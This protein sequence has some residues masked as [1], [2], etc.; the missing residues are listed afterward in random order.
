MLAWP[1]VVHAAP[2]ESESAPVV[3][4]TAEALWEKAVTARDE[5]KILAAAVYFQRF[6]KRF[7]DSDQ[8]EDALWQ[9]AQLAKKHA[10]TANDPNWRYVRDLFKRYTVDY[11][12]SPRYEEAYYEQAV[13]YYNMRM[14]REALIYFNLFLE[15]FPKSTFAQQVSYLK[16]Q[17]FLKIGRLADATKI[18]NLLTESKDQSL[19]LQGFVG[20]GDAL[21]AGGQNLAALA[22]YKKV[23]SKS[24][25]Y[26][27]E[28]PVLL[29]KL[30]KTYFRVGN[31]D[32]GRKQLFHYLNLD[33]T[34]HRR[35]EVVFEIGESFHR[36]G[37]EDAAQRLYEMAVKEGAQD[38]RSVVLSLFRQAQHR[39]DP[40]REIP[41]WKKPTDLTDPAG[42][43]PY[44]DV[45]DR[46]YGEPIAQDARLA[47][48]HR[49]QARKDI[50]Q[51]LSVAVSFIQ[52][53][54]EGPRRLEMESLVGD[55]LVIR[56]QEYLAAGRYQDIYD[57]YRADYRHV[58][59][60]RKG[61]LLYLI[62]QALEGLTLYDQAAVIYYRALALP[63]SDVDKADLYY[64]RATVYI[65]KKDWTAADRL[66]THLRKTYKGDQV[67]GEYIYLSGCLREAQGKDDEAL[68][69]YLEAIDLLA[70][71]VRKPLC[72]KAALKLLVLKGRNDETRSLL[73]RF[74]KDKWLTPDEMQNWYS[75]LADN[76][77]RAG[78]NP[79]AVKVYL[80]ALAKGMPQE[81]ELT[82]SLQVRLGGTFV[83][84]GR[85]EEA[86]VYFDKARSGSSELWRRVAGE[87]L[88]Q[89]EIDSS[90]L[91]LETILSQ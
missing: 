76:L 12:K 19:R 43:K 53:E 88:A 36:Q 59:A 31:E 14:F 64:R 1:A 4:L 84:L 34:S 63:L 44:L 54:P 37:D 49:Y 16:G 6:Q 65:A 30:G 91:T 70:G 7:P 71:S 18:F 35:S 48:I 33:K 46:Y 42:D 22:A 25:G 13:A 27:F 20:L 86:K 15:R 38:E 24:P 85:L 73:A 41:D 72:A 23:L 81:G 80:M 32:Q 89:M 69:Y 45:V 79:G 83:L 67:A 56:V 29:I 68:T 5:G 39:D 61:R 57:L 75:R 90:M 58:V 82:Q 40:N 74:A 17:T 28:Y 26:F 62:G 55:L 52:H 3:L 50:E 60:Y 21:Y 11:T 87:R 47:I 66:L 2:S 78:D 8:A 10:L 9:A 51:Q 77:L